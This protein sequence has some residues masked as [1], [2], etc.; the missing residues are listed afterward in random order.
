MSPQSY[1]LGLNYKKTSQQ[2]AL[3]NFVEHTFC[4]EQTYITKV[5]DLPIA[6]CPF[7]QYDIC[8]R[9]SCHPTSLIDCR[10]P[11]TQ[12]SFGDV[13]LFQASLVKIRTRFDRYSATLQEIFK[14]PL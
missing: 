9:P 14:I 3:L 1:Q 5:P 12:V 6:R 4:I 8:F 10:P 13:A 11:V 2:Q 7:G